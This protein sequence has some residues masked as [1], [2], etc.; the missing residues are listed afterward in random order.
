MYL[1]T[2]R[3]VSHLMPKP[4]ILI[5]ILLLSSWTLAQSSLTGQVIDIS[6]GFEPDP[7]SFEYISG[8]PISVEA[9]IGSDANGNECKGFI[10]SEPDHTLVLRSDFPNLRIFV[11]AARTEDT[12]M[13]IR[14]E[15]AS[16]TLC[17][18]DVSRDNPHPSIARA[19]TAGIYYIYIGSFDERKM[20]NYTIVISE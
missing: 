4:I 8:G 16:L 20:S 1:Y 6:P 3:K 5:L 10:A 12:T 15:D 2:P 9:E 19:F 13:V 17:H 14:S 7:L 18:D 11:E